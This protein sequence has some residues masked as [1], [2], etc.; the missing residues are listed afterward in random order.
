MF[1]NSLTCS[2]LNL[3]IGFAEL[4]K[5][6]ENVL[7]RRKSKNAG[8]V[9]PSQ[10]K[11]PMSQLLAGTAAVSA[12]ALFHSNLHRERERERERERKKE[13]ALSAFSPFSFQFCCT[14]FILRKILFVI[15]SVYI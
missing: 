9:P 10:A 6:D 12:I 13:C 1:L 5:Y 14:Y 11:V 8:P 2:Q 15:E 4:C 7:H 3:E